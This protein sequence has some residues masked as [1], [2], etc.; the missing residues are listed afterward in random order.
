VKRTTVTKKRSPIDYLKETAKR[1][2]T[3]A[4]WG[5]LVLIFCTLIA[6]VASNTGMA[7]EYYEFWEKKFIV[8]SEDFALNMTFHHWVNDG[9]MVIFF[10]VIGL[11]LKREILVGALSDW[12]KASMP[13][14]AAIGGM[15]V[16][17]LIYWLFNAGTAYEKGWGIPMATDIAYSLGLLGLLGTRVPPSLK[18]FLTALAIVD[19]LGAIL[20]IAFFYSEGI[21]W[22]YLSIGLGI[23]GGLFLINYLGVRQGWVYLLTGIF[24]WYAIF[25]SGIHATIAGILLAATIPLKVRLQ[26]RE[27]MEKTEEKLNEL[28][29]TNL[30][31]G[32][33]LS[34]KKHQE[35]IKNIRRFT[36]DSRSPLLRS[37]SNL[38]YLSAFFIIPIFALANAGVTFVEGWSNIFT[39]TLGLGIIL[40]LVVGKFT[41]V[42]LFS[43]LAHQLGLSKLNVNLKW[44]DIAGMA[45]LT[46]VG[47][48]MS[49]FIS[50]LAFGIDSDILA[51]AKMAILIAS[52]IAAVIGFTTLLLTPSKK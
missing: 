46:G 41:G 51:N 30:E 14:Y 20:I 10:L 5:G 28:K 9:L 18:I 42:F 1:F 11:E 27:F 22:H 3:N 38:S 15:I 8:A 45:L 2:A 33:A 29:E 24:L 37:E 44:S 12:G 32:D 26:S 31:R 36:I 43:F 35:I 39:S 6:L 47:F 16:P 7:D 50:N 21:N 40:G 34:E 13:V 17:A 48:T 49:L 52:A 25:M 19:D 23:T 4:T